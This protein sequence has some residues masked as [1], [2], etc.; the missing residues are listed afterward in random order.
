[1]KNSL[2]MMQKMM[3]P[4]RISVNDSFNPIIVAV[5]FAPLDIKAIRRDVTNMY[6]GLKCASHDTMIAVKPRLCTELLATV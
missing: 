6:S 3:M 2:P 5:S 1:M 4:T